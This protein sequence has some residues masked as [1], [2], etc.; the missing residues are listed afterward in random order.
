[1]FSKPEIDYIKSQRLAR[2][3][4]VD[5]KNNHPDVVPV[6]FEFDGNYFWIGSH[7]QDIFF[8]TK[9][10]KNVR[11]GNNKVGLVIDD[12]KTVQ[13]WH[14]R[15]LKVNGTAEVMEHEGI[16][17][18]GKYLRVTPKI[19]WSIGIEGLNLKEG[20]WRLKTFHEYSD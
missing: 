17:G 11:D 20:Q 3:G 9:K 14:P 5:K 6:G 18:P 4:T 16:F 19:S 12:L 10:Y 15:C 7:D 8:V 13:P 1:M 2:I